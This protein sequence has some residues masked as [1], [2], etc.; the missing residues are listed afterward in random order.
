MPGSA[1]SAGTGSQIS[2]GSRRAR[3]RQYHVVAHTSQVDESLFGTPNNKKET[4]NG[5]SGE[6]AIEAQARERSAQREKKKRKNKNNKESV[7]VITKDLIRNLIVPEEDPSGQ[8]MVLHYGDYLRLRNSARVLTDVEKMEVLERAKQS[9]ESAMDSAQ[10]RKN[11]MKL[12]DLQRHKN[13][14]LTEIEQEEHE[15]AEYL[16]KKANQQRQE[17][18][19]EIKYLNE[20]ILN[21]KCHAIR[22]AQILEK[23]QISGEMMDEEKR[24]DMM[25]EADR[26]RALQVQE[27]I[28]KKRR[29]E[30]LLGAMKIMEQIQENEQERLLELERKDQENKSKQKYLDKLCEEEAERL[31]KKREEQ[32]RL[33][34]QLNQ[35]NSDI[36][37]RKELTKE[38]EKLIDQQVL[39]YQQEKAE[40]EQAFEQEQERIRIEKEKEVALLRA[41]QERARDEQAER[42]ALRAKRDQ[43]RGERE[44][45]Q[46]EA[47][48]SRKK[49][50]TES[51]LKQARSQQMEQK[52]HFLAVQ[53]QR[54]RADFER[55]LRAQKELVEKEKRVEVE[56][57]K[58]RDTYAEDVRVQIGEKENMRIRQ[59]QSFF[60]EGVK[61]DE[62]ARQ[63]RL[64]LDDI[65]RKKLE[66]LRAMGLHDKYVK[67]VS[68]KANVAMA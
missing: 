50:E 13:Q 14:A 5:N 32:Q 15:K 40:R 42:D 51:M 25:M 31:N 44:W 26:Q 27:E 19:D 6:P 34:E 33:R 43:E 3:T 67:Q 1:I 22:D 60:E 18:E 24:L 45:R 65:K 17:Q 52:E 59:R 23:G 55:V 63:R 28:E 36:I 9:K 2:S 39:K 53:A 48:M 29:D 12:H 66:E 16:Q 64:K 38:Q 68:R 20:M 21:A 57:R 58:E 8:S 30:R 54:E 46:K 47:E 49:S 7:Q 4:W 37:Q 41:K 10:D 11:D 35:C 61:L 56:K 62:E